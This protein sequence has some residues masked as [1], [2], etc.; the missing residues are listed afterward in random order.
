VLDTL[1]GNQLAALR[2]AGLSDSEIAGQLPTL[3][4]V[5]LFRGTTAGFP[6]NSAL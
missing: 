3:G 5:Q 2:A 4:D 6:G 1:T